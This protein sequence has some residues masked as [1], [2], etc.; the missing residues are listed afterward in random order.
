LSEIVKAVRLDLLGNEIPLCDAQLLVLRVAGERDHVHAIEQSAGD[1]VGC[2]CRADEEDLREIEGQVE[3]V[4]A[5]RLVLLG[6]E[7][8]EHRGCRIAADVGAHL[9]DL[10]DEQHRIQRLGV[11]ERA[12]HRAGHRTDVRAPVPADLGLV[13]DAADR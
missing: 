11:A 10:V 3:V 12:D 1:R 5:E 7:N 6:V 8:L 2:V 9:V 4:I 13:A